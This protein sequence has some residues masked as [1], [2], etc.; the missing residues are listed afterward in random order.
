MPS[1]LNIYQR[2]YAKHPSLADQ[3]TH[4]YRLSRVKWNLELVELVRVRTRTISWFVVYDYVGR[5]EAFS[6]LSATHAM[7]LVT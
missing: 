6:A 3:P 4:T 2:S 5:S 7:D 1:E